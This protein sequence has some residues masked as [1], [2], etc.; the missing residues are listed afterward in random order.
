MCA[1]LPALRPVFTRFGSMVSNSGFSLR[2]G[3][4]SGASGSRKVSSATG[5]SGKSGS[6]NHSEKGRSHYGSASTGS[7]SE[8]E[9]GHDSFVPARPEN[10]RTKAWYEEEVAEREDVEMGNAGGK[11]RDGIQVRKDVEWRESE[12]RGGG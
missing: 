8:P 4:G 10:T 12:R 1:C 9:K 11:G 5:A 3:S 7:E 6:H 2:S